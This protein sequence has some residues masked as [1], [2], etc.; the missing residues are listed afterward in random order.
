MLARFLP[1][2]L[3]GAPPL[4]RAMGMMLVSSL[5]FIC[6]HALVARVSQDLPAFEVAF[7]R[8]LFGLVWLLPALIRSRFLALKTTKLHLHALRGVTN[9]ASMLM[10][11]S[12]L[13]FTPL[14]QA[15]A[16]AYTSPLFVTIGAA[17]VLGETFRIRRLT[18][19]AFGFAGMLL[20]LR[21]GMIEIGTGPLLV[22]G[23]AVLWAVA[24]ID[25][26]ILS[27]TDSSLTIAA[28][29]VV[30]L[31]PVTFIAALFVWQWPTL[32]QLGWL[33]LVAAFG[34]VG[35]LL[36]NEAFRHA[37]ATVLM[38]LDFTKLIWASLIGFFAFG[39]I[40]DLW[41]WIGGAVIFSSATYISYREHQISRRAAGNGGEPSKKR[42]AAS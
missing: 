38:P 22:I 4:A 2:A 35:H 18:A 15:T 34:T 19:L 20:V 6:M 40:P 33:M 17:V 41:T 8:N 1:A 26:K 36:F 37:D 21:P 9:S 31:T 13:A 11:F 29:M 30:F 25:I 23:S 5:S 10:F 24:M 28:Y 7:F 39:Q 14:A 3:T 27:R 42:A 12:A 32:A 16:L